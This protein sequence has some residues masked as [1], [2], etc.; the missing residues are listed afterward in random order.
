MVDDSFPDAMEHADFVIGQSFWTD[1]GEW[2]CTDIGTRV[3]VAI[4]ANW[5]DPSWHNGP[6]YALA[7]TVFDEYDFGACFLAEAD[8]IA[9]RG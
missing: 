6:P 3:I 9:N 7:E 8:L 5:D 4:K 1:T 2:I